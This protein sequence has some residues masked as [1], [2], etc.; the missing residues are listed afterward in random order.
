MYLSNKRRSKHPVQGCRSQNQTQT[1]RRCGVLLATC[2]VYASLKL[3]RWN[4]KVSFCDVA[5]RTYFQLLEKLLTI[6]VEAGYELEIEDHRTPHNLAFEHVTQTSYDH[7]MWP[8]R[9]PAAGEPMVSRIQQV[10]LSDLDVYYTHHVPKP[11]PQTLF[12][13]T[14]S[15]AIT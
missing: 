9:H 12:V 11:A 8:K 10:A 4:G 14:W 3:G 1:Q 5:G 15:F 13:A 2:Y 7:V 6:V